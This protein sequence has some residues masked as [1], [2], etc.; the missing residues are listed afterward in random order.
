MY[1]L[2]SSIPDNERSRHRQLKGLCLHKLCQF[3]GIRR[4]NRSDE[5]PIPLQPPHLGL[6]RLQKRCERRASRLGSRAPP[7]RTKSPLPSRSS[8]PTFRR[9]PAH[10]HHATWHDFGP[11][12]SARSLNRSST[13]STACAGQRPSPTSSA[14]PASL[15]VSGGH[16]PTPVAAH[17]APASPRGAAHCSG[18]GRAPAS[19]SYAGDFAGA[20]YAAAAQDDAAPVAGWAV[21]A[22]ARQCGGPTRA[23]S[24]GVCAASAAR[25]QAAG[26]L[27]AASAGVCREAAVSA[28]GAPAAA[29]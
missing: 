22:A 24:G 7:R 15:R 10:G 23:V 17:A 16:S 18:S 6:L 19:A 4:F 29:A 20:R 28:Q 11:S 26:E 27:A 25:G 3:R 8:P 13:A 1:R 21:S 12:P 2:F 14:R 9:R 5:R